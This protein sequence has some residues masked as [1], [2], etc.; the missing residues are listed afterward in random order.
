VKRIGVLAL[1]GGFAEHM[2]KL[3][4]ISSVEAVL[5]KKREELD[6]LDGLILPGGESTAMGRLL[7]GEKLID[8]LRKKIRGGLPVWGTCAGMILLAGD[9][10]GQKETYLDVMHIRVRRNAYGRQTESFSSDSPCP[11]VD[12]GI[13]RLI[14]IRAPYITGTAASVDI[15]LKLDGHIV[16]AKEGTMLA[17]SFHPELTDDLWF[18]QYFA[19]QIQHSPSVL[20]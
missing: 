1:Q 18:H 8:I 17:T 4:Q 19:E 16:A 14:F 2:Q 11:S 12:K 6:G 10:E 5:V 7:R 9:I 13:H 3:R 20:T 15:L